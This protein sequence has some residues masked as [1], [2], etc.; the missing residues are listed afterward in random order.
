MRLM[1]SALSTLCI[2]LAVVPSFGVLDDAFY[3]SP[4]DPS[5]VNRFGLAA[6][7]STVGTI[8]MFGLSRT[9]PSTGTAPHKE[10]NFA[11]CTAAAAFLFAAPIAWMVSQDAVS[12]ILRFSS[13]AACNPLGVAIPITWIVGIAPAVVPLFDALLSQYCR[14][15]LRKIWPPLF[16]SA[17]SLLL[18]VVWVLLL[19]L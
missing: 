2:V 13:V 10:L 12:T 8:M 9:L 16:A 17:L 5:I 11:L 19:L 15:R 1:L 4:P 3:C 7:L 18:I 6:G 14:R